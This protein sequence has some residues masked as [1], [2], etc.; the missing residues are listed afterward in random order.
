MV[1][2]VSRRGALHLLTLGSASSALVPGGSA[3]AKPPAAA[4]PQ[5]VC[6]LYPQ[7]VEGPFYFDPILVRPDISEGQVGLPLEIQLRVIES[8]SCTP[9]KNARVDIWH[10]DAGGLYSGYAG[11][12][13][14]RDVSTKGQTYLRGTQMSD[15]DGRVGFR[16]IY[17][18]WYPGRTPHI[19]VK[20]FLDAKSLVTGQMYFPDDMSARVYKDSAPYNSRPVA[21]TTNTADFIYKSGGPGGGGTLLHASTDGKAVTAALLIAVDRSGTAAQKAGGWGGWLRGLFYK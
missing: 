12:G 1:N 10:A 15:A 3:A 9:I 21:D 13:A 11:Q 4:N 16:S 19:H 5:G 8:G 14:K 18:G 17:P 7:S 6:V 20:I 2:K